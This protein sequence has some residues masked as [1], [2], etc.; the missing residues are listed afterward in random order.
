MPSRR[1]V[2][3]ACALVLFVSCR[4]KPRE[5][6]FIDPALALLVP[7]DTVSLAGVRMEKL[8]ATP[9]FQKYFLNSKSSQFEKFR[10]QTGIDPKKDVWELLIAGTRTGAVVVCRGKFSEFGMEPKLP[11]PEAKR[12][13]YRGYSLVGNEQYALVY[14]NPST[15]MAGPVAL[16]HHVLDSRDKGI[17]GIPNALQPLIKNVPVDS[18]LWIA[19]D[20]AAQM[21]ALNP[22]TAGELGNFGQFAGSIQSAQGSIDL[23][24]GLKLAMV[25]DCRSPQD[26]ERLNSTFRALAG[27]GRLSTPPERLDLMHA[28][29]ALHS[30]IRN[31]KSVSV[32]AT[33]TEPEL[34]ALL[35]QVYKGAKL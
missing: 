2:A 14:L 8:R 34:E 24:S 23:R 16:L 11:Y 17:L 5:D 30:E 22:K 35:D 13:S 32:G 25:A 3:L 15:A 27:M 12:Y 20:I 9:A 1:L 19:G 33:L 6:I 28:W 29:D 31:Q 21:Q 7:A 4:P 10:E 18:Q 26:A